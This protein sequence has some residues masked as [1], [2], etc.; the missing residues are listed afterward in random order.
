MPKPHQLAVVQRV[1]SARS[2]RFVLADEVGLGKTIEAGMVYAAMAQTGLAKRVLIVTPAHLSVQWLAEMYHKF[3][4]MFTLLDGERLAKEAEEDPR[5]AWWRFPKV[6]TSLE[7][8]AR[9]EEHREAIGDPA[10]RWDLVIFDEAHHLTS[11]KAYEA[12]EAAA[13]NT[14]GL[15]LLTA[16]PLQ[17]DPLE[18]FKLLSLVDP[19]TPESFEEFEARLERQGDLSER[20][21]ELLKA[22]EPKAAARAAKAITKIL[23]EDDALIEG[24]SAIADGEEGASERFVSHLAEAYSISSRLIRNRRAM[25]GGLAPRRLVRHDV[26]LSADELAFRTAVNEKLAAGELKASGA[27]LASLLKRLDSSPRAA[28]AALTAQKLPEL[29]EQ[30]KGLEGP[31]RDAKAKA[32]LDLVKKVRKDEAGAKLLVFAEA[33]ETMEYVRDVLARGGIA[34]GVYHGDLPQLERDRQVARF[35]DPEGPPVLVSTEVGGEGR[36][37]QFCH[38]LVNFDL[39]WSPAAIEQRIGRLDRI[40][41]NHEVRIH[42]FR[43]EGTV[44]AK[45]FDLMADAV[46]VFD[47]T[48][49]GLDPVLERVESEVARQVATAKDLDEYQAKLAKRVAQAREEVRRAYDPL[50]DAR[51]FDKDSVR[52]L[53]DRASARLGLDSLDGEELEESLWRVAREL[54]ERLEETVIDLARKVGIHADCEEHVDAFQCSFKIGSELAVDALPGFELEEDQAVL[55]SFWRDT[56]V[57]EEENDYFATGHPLVEALFAWIRDGEEGRASW[58]LSDAMRPATFGFAFTFLPAFPEAEDLAAGSKVPSRQAARYLHKQRF[59]VAV[60]LARGSD[61][62]RVRDE[63]LEALEDPDGAPAPRGSS[64]NVLSAAVSAAFAAAK[65]E[66]EARL[67]VEKAAAIARLEADRDAAIGRLELAARRADDLELHALRAE[68]RRISESLDTARRALEAIR[69]DLDQ[70]A[71]LLPR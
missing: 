61:R 56:A 8:L 18:H 13:D 42:C 64:G 59:P 40:G 63:L 65:E 51:S 20:L 30:A 55:G 24:A 31:S 50:L 1:L 45:V 44:G 53:V 10:G 23:P 27:A 9:S 66:A 12:A 6:V 7:L 36:N 54:D 11:P 46:R 4:S 32:L 70:A 26:K 39:A 34:A 17:L 19:A 43:V 49:G 2:P 48:V 37:F 29:A 41:Q 47:E 25:V 22:K 21:R 62:P 16:T 5:P 28:A 60:E 52:K 67:A 15:L 35:R 58:L 71:G 38:H 14:H 3:H 33:R 69:L 68:A 57:V